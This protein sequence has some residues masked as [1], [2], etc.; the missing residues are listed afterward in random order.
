VTPQ[1]HMCV[2]KPPPCHALKTSFDRMMKQLMSSVVRRKGRIRRS[3]NSSPQIVDMM[4]LCG[5]SWS[6]YNE[7]RPWY[8]IRSC[9]ARKWS[10]ENKVDNDNLVRR[11]R[12]KLS[13][14]VIFC[15][16]G[17]LLSSEH[18][19]FLVFPYVPMTSI[20]HIIVRRMGDDTKIIVS[21]F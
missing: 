6:W 12:E 16:M 19:A 8:L 13:R 4:I 9:I 21:L 2:A 5:I 17:I 10:I 15:G 3:M 18:I 11:I 7:K 20:Y 14:M 1:A